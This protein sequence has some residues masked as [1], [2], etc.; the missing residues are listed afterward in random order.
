[1]RQGIGAPAV[2]SSGVVRCRLKR[3]GGT[4]SSSFLGTAVNLRGRTLFFRSAGASNQKGIFA[5]AIPACRRLAL[6]IQETSATPAKVL[7]FSVAPWT[8]EPQF[9][10]GGAVFPVST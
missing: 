6:A 1:V 7:V 10:V 2:G 4:S 9:S 3:W 8:Y 5:L